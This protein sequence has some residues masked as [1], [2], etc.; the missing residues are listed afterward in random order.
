M[1]NICS[2]YDNFSQVSDE[3]ESCIGNIDFWL[4]FLI[5]LRVILSVNDEVKHWIEVAILDCN[6]VN[7]DHV[8][9]L[10]HNRGLV[11]VNPSFIGWGNVK[12][13]NGCHEECV[14]FLDDY[15]MLCILGLILP[16][17]LNSHPLTSVSQS[18]YVSSN[19]DELWDMVHAMVFQLSQLEVLGVELIPGIVVNVNIQVTVGL[20]ST[21]CQI[22]L[23][24]LIRRQIVVKF[25]NLFHLSLVLFRELLNLVGSILLL[26]CI[27][28][29]GEGEELLCV[30]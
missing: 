14:L 6:Q 9:D 2:W 29:L 7:V 11:W 15:F 10:K 20:S 12:L 26:Q 17:F 30:H 4:H 27:D 22:H 21:D 24:S 25:N 19:L 1:N 3:Q 5:K 28:I 13:V 18:M 8:P 16:V 23:S